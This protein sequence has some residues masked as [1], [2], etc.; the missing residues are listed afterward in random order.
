ML[1]CPGDLVVYRKFEA[2]RRGSNSIMLI[3]DRFT[4][5]KV[6]GAYYRVFDQGDLTLCHGSQIQKLGSREN[7]N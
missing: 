2:A 7:F 3:I 6:E 1:F 5:I 4:R